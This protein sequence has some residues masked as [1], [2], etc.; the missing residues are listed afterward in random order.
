MQLLT[1]LPKIWGLYASV[2]DSN[3]GS[4]GITLTGVKDD[5]AVFRLVERAIHFF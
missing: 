4:D 5:I 1:F 2:M 3:H